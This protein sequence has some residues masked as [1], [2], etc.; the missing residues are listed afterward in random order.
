MQKKC[1][2]NTRKETIAMAWSRK[3]HGQKKDFD[4]G[5]KIVLKE[6]GLRYDPE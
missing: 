5:I 3:H 1:V 6:R 2:S 4:T